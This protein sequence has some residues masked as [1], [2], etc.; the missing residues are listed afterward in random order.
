M[1]TDTRRSRLLK[2]TLGLAAGSTIFFVAGLN[3]M[4]YRHAYALTHF[5]RTGTRT[6]RP[7][8]LSVPEK[9]QVLLTGATVPRPRNR[10]NPLDLGL[11]YERHVFAGAHG[12]PVEAWYIPRRHGRGLVAMFHGHADSKDSQLRAASVFQEM[13]YSTLLVDFHGSGGSGGSETSVGFHE[14]TDVASAYVYGRHLPGERVVI[15]YG[16]SMGAAAILKAVADTSIAPEA[17]ILECPFDSLLQTVRHRFAGTG[18]PSFPAAELLVFWGGW[19]QGFDGFRHNPAEN[20]R[21]VARPALLMNGDRDPWV[22]L[23][24]ARTIFDHLQ[25]PKEIKIFHGL[26]HQSFLNARPEEWKRSVSSF[27]AQHS[28][29]NARE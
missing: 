10:R 1:S 28:D 17:L 9:L 4:A 19:Q 12:L 8:S 20:A 26:R 2:R 25:G 29:P 24:E 13:G 23:E 3:M 21:A 22:T 14:A 27:L 11:A 6:P 16:G 15:L 7:E 5:A 18:L